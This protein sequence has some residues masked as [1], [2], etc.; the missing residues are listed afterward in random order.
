MDLTSL[1]NE[2]G[3][4]LDGRFH[5]GTKAQIP[6]NVA[7]RFKAFA[8]LGSDILVENLTRVACSWA[9]CLAKQTPVCITYSNSDDAKVSSDL[10]D[11]EIF[12]PRLHSALGN[13]ANRNKSSAEL[14][15]L[16]RFYGTRLYYCGV[17]QCSFFHSGFTGQLE[18][19]LHESKH[20][21]P[22]ACSFESCPRTAI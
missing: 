4:F 12:I 3:H 1:T 13:L 6:P 20:A 9:S 10:T 19:D 21:T 11:L 16:H 17:I 7:Q 18:R 8:L 15:D 14:Q 22:L 2:L 5:E